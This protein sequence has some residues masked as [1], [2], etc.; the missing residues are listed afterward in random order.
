MHPPARLPQLP[1]PTPLPGD[2]IVRSCADCPTEYALF[3][4]PGPGQIRCAAYRAAVDVA[5]RWARQAHVDVW[6]ADGTKSFAL[7][8]RHRLDEPKSEHPL[9]GARPC[10]G[11][12]RD[13]DIDVVRGIDASPPNALLIGS[14]TVAKELIKLFDPHLAS[15]IVEWDPS[16]CAALPPTDHGTLVIWNVD[17]MPLH[18]QQRLDTF[19]EGHWRSVHIVSVADDEFF[20]RVERGE[21]LASLY[22]RLNEVKVHVAE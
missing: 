12:E 7:L 2:V 10:S 9:L 18:E 16:S 19:I 21:F 8:S 3:P 1:A 6:F 5:K 22:Y 4:E 14:A 13:D 15:P 17:R 20:N 11:F